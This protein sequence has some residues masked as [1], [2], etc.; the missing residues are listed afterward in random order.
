MRNKIVSLAALFAICLS[1]M[2]SPEK[3]FS[4]EQSIRVSLPNFQDKLNG[5]TD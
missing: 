4:A 2:A 3:S 1:M 5:N